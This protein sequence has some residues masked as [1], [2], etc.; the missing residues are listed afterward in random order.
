MAGWAGPSN[1]TSKG[2]TASP[3]ARSMRLSIPLKVHKQPLPVCCRQHSH[4]LA[5]S[6]GTTRFT[7]LQRPS[8]GSRLATS[9]QAT[10]RFY[11]S[12]TG[13]A[14]QSLHRNRRPCTQTQASQP[15]TPQPDNSG[16]TPVPKNQQP[17][18]FGSLEQRIVDNLSIQALP[19]S[20]DDWCPVEGC[21][22]LGPP[23]G[24]PCAP[25]LLSRT[26]A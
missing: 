22:V 16:L 20:R 18:A 23:A 15:P 25:D 11:P 5:S 13:R 10:I 1:S 4:L 6:S 17:T 12:G 3:A 8:S 24:H 26:L 7:V 2:I 14:V 19:G 21:W 9:K